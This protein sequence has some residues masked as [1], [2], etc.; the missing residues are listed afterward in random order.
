MSERPVL[1]P[2]PEHPITIAPTRGQVT[3][4]I[5]GRVVAETVDALTLQESNYPAVQYLPLADVDQSVLARS[6]TTS[7]C[8]YK[9]E[10][11]YY[12]VGD[13]EDVIWTYEQPYPAVAEIA[14]RVAFYPNKADIVVHPA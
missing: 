12:H 5:N 10:A 3:V 6:T 2:G 13:V 14:G 9:G 1:Q 4:T 8:P 11:G 7:Y